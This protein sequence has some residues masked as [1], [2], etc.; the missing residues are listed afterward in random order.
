MPF[1]ENDDVVE[2]L[3]ADRSD[4]TLAVRILP[5][6]AWGR[7]DILDAH[8]LDPPDEA[9]AEDAV[10]V[11]HQE[12]GCAFVRKG[13]DDLLGGPLSGGRGRDVEVQDAGADRGT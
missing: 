10:A 4:Q 13:L 7:D 8:R 12:A 6:R 11:M 1:I 3:P 9:V 2:A 5:R